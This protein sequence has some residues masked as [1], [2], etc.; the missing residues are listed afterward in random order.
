[1]AIA[2]YE[3]TRVKSHVWIFFASCS[4]GNALRKGR[5]T[6]E[7]HSGHM[8]RNLMLTKLL[9]KRTLRIWRVLILPR[10]LNLKK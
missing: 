4:A 5:E 2:D 9:T 6:G 1:V 10:S 7:F 3:A 8:R